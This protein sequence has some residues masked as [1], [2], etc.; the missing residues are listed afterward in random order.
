MKTTILLFQCPDRVGILSE[1]LYFLANLGANVI[2]VDQ[3]STEEETPFFFLRLEFQLAQTEG[4]FSIF[5]KNLSNT[6]LF[7][8][9]IWELHPLGDRQKMG[10]LVSKEGHCLIEV[11]NYWE[12]GD[13]ELDIPFVI[14]NHPIFEKVVKAHGIPFYYL[15]N[16][17]EVE[18][19]SLAKSCDF[20]VLA[21]YMQI[22]SKSFLDAFSRPV[23][24]IHHSFLPSFKGAN[25]YRQAFE[26]GVKVIGATTHYVTEHLDDGPIITQ[27]LAQVSHRDGLDSIR[28]KSKKLEKQGLLEA[29]QLQAEY[30]IL[31][32][33][34][35]TIIF[36]S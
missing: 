5:E 26:R 2:H 24:N 20:L 13:L 27:T 33:G 22:L 28:R 14:S 11:L 3:H 23:I 34:K 19:L 31:R 18:I 10:L 32:H 9:A 1:I 35:K 15:P 21:R 17:S 30:R 7:S 16:H 4:L 36:E 12:S 29:I 8:C 25:P 6:D